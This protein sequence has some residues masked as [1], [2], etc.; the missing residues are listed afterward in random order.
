MPDETRIP[1]LPEVRDP[2]EVRTML[3][4]A[5]ATNDSPLFDSLCLGYSDEIAD[6]FPSWLEVPEP[7]HENRR[8]LES[9][10][11]MLTSG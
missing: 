1:P 9:Y 11:V 2:E 8:D 6:S 10:F 4:R 7:I 5:V 3:L